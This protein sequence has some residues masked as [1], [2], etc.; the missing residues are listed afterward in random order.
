MA[1]ER[2]VVVRI[3]QSKAA[4]DNLNDSIIHGLPAAI[5]MYQLKICVPIAVEM[6]HLTPKNTRN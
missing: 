1:H 3:G 2:L 6:I 4:G 5:G